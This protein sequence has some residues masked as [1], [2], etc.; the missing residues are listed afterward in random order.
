MGLFQGLTDEEY[1]KRADALLE[2]PWGEW[3]S[4]QRIAAEEVKRDLEDN[5]YRPFDRWPTT[6][7]CLVLQRQQ[8]HHVDPDLVGF[9]PYG[10]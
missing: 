8:E 4:N 9:D 6:P 1:D 2:T 10:D 5:P 3:L 7:T